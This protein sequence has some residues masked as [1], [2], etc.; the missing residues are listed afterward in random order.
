MAGAEYTG[1]GASVKERCLALS[2]PGPSG[3]SIIDGKVMDAGK[4]CWHDKEGKKGW[5][6]AIWQ[7]S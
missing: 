5:N 6:S 1:N 7:P 3:Q 2:L 4:A